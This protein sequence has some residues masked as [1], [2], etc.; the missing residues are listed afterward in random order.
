MLLQERILSFLFRMR[1]NFQG[2]SW[3]EFDG[4][5]EDELVI[6]FCWIDDLQNLLW[7]LFSVTGR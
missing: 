7:F 3:F 6:R 1:P 2:L 4:L 5:V